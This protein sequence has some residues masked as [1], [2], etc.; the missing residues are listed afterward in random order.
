[1]Q[2]TISR[3]AFVAS[4]AATLASIGVLRSTAQAAALFEYKYGHDLNVDHPLHVRSVQ[5]WRAVREETRGRLNVTVYPNNQLGNDPS[6]VGQLR[7]GA[8]QFLA[9]QGANISGVVPLA[10]IDSVGFAFKTTEEATR[11]FDGELGEALR[12]EFAAKGLTGFDRGVFDLGFREITSS[13]KPI[14]N[15]AD[16]A[17]FKIRTPPAKIIVDLFRTLG[18]SPT[19]IAFGELYTALQTH[20]VDG[21]ETPYA[22]IATQRFYEVQKYLSVSNHLWTGFFLV[23]NAEAYSALPDDIRTVVERNVRKYVALERR[24]IALTNAATVDRLRRLGMQINDVDTSTMRAALNPYYARWK[25]EFGNAAWS[26]LEKT[27]GKLG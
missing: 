11:A 20:V 12:K 17:N 25:S 9:I 5:L 1:M 18:A 19:P 10:G 26:A 16:L 21:Q 24:D 7:T 4:T 15:A 3:G 14:H 13:T 22:V 6:M 2:R 23:A 8:M 27:T